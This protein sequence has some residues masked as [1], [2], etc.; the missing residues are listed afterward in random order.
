MELTDSV[1]F[2]DIQLLFHILGQFNKK[3]TIER[4]LFK[5]RFNIIF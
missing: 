2:H 4:C 5:I 1:L 3:H